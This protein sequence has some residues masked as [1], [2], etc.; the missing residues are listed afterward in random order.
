MRQTSFFKIHSRS[1]DANTLHAPL[2]PFADTIPT[3]VT[4]PITIPIPITPYLLSLIPYL[5]FLSTCYLLLVNLL[6]VTDPHTHSRR[7][8]RNRLTSNK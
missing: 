1:S 3:T 8:T 6:L 2:H 5:L 4:I 7:Y